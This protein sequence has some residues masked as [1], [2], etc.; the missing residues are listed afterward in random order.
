MPSFL[1]NEASVDEGYVFVSAFYDIG[2]ETWP[3]KYSRSVQTY[4]NRFALLVQL[5][6][7]LV[8]FMDDRYVNNVEDI[9][10]EHSAKIGKPSSTIIIK[11][12]EDFLTSFVPSWNYVSIENDIMTSEQYISL[13]RTRSEENTPETKYA[14]YTCINH[15]K[16]DFAM[17][18][19]K[20][21]ENMGLYINYIGWVD[22]GYF[23]EQ[24]E[25][26]PFTLNKELLFNGK[27]NFLSHGEFSD[28]EID[29]VYVF[30]NVPIK[31]GGAF[32]F[33]SIESVM[34]YG[35]L[36]HEC[37]EEMHRKNL[38]DDDQ[39]VVICCYFKQKQLFNMWNNSIRAVID[40]VP[41]ILWFL[42]FVLFNEN[43]INEP[44]VENFL[45][46]NGIAMR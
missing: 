1:D 21:C 33:G 29:P 31:V 28:Q 39:S 41:Q 8:L 14:S 13:A 26:V 17:L 45:R 7:P 30:S 42:A 5:N 9:V 6:L 4:L 3:T 27:I 12:G 24:F 15:A 32:W 38:A 19:I 36:Y 20:Y 40:G 2:R 44:V 23:T 10:N 16:I 43:F 37:V 35:V 18:A 34:Q 25:V 22:F 46:D 11:I